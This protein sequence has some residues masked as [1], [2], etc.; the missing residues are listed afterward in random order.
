M[1]V[2]RQSYELLKSGNDCPV[3]GNDCPVEGT[4][5]YDVYWQP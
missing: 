5:T 2:D 1:S 3:K 4:N